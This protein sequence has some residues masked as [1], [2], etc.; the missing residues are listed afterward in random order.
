M[1][2]IEIQE[3][4]GIESKR[5]MGLLIVNLVLLSLHIAERKMKND[6]EP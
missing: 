6:E 5:K 2:N 3:P 1:F 4:L